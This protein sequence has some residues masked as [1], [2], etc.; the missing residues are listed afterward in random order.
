MWPFRSLVRVVTVGSRDWKALVSRNDSS[1]GW[2]AEAGSRAETTTSELRERAPTFGTLYAYPFC[3]EEAMQDVFFD[4]G[5][6]LVEEAADGFAAA[7]ATAIVSGNGSARPTGFLNSTPVTTDDGSPARAA[8]TLEYI[9]IT[10]PSSP[11]TS[12]GITAKTLVDL[13]MS[14]KEKYTLDASKVAWVMR[15][16]TAAH[17]MKLTDTNG[18][19]LWQNGLASGQ[20]P[21]LLGYP[22][23]L[24]DAMPAN[25][26]GNYPIAFG[27]WAR[28]YVLA[29]RVGTMRI[30][31]DDN[32]S[33]PGYHKF[34]LRRVVGGCIYNHEAVKV[35]K[36]GLT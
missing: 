13:S 19:F 17:V 23:K 24:T 10:S 34:Y 9:P 4:V 5:Q 35:I 16:S 25:T 18:Q 7:E 21:S 8:T 26:V 22:V 2:V 30:T 36:Y 11:Y 33:A 1:S 29:D 28:G 20:P 15:R 32:I 27:N 12:T 6:W 3:T 31:H 14:V